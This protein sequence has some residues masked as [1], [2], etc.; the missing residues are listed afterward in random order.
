MKSYDELKAL[1]E[2][3]GVHVEFGDA[4]EGWGIEQ[5]PHELASFLVRMQEL[6]VQ[7]VLEIGTGYKGGLSRFLAADL[8]WQVTTYDIKNYG[9]VFT[10]VHY[11]I[12]DEA[13][14]NVEYPHFLEKFDLVFIDANHAYDEVKFDYEYY[15]NYATK[16]IAF[17]D[18]AGLRGCEGVKQ[19][20]GENA[21]SEHGSL[22]LTYRVAGDHI[23][24]RQ[25]GIGWIEL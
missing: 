12:G 11:I 9:H 14:L 20:W 21:Y 8:G 2:Q 15:G 10:G 25:A 22:K 19:F 17:H 1:I 6:G 3:R 7:S 13:W 18:I 5:N 24:S 4:G 16:V 23:V